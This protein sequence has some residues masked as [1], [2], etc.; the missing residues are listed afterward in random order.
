MKV[1]INKCFG[2]YGLNMKA[3]KEIARLKGMQLWFYT[4]SG[5]IAERLKMVKDEVE[6]FILVAV[7]KNFGN[8]ATWGEIDN[9]IFNAKELERNDK[10]LTQAL[11]NLGV[12]NCNTRFSEL[13]IV[14]IPD[15]MEYE[16][17][18]YDGVETLHEKHRSW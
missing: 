8:E 15:G 7:T 12:K 11:E 14:K 17:T 10:D 18:D 6:P 16:I 9:F 3:Q 4:G 13:K 2:G 5:R 1:V